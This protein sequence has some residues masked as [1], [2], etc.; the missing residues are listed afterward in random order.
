MRIEP[1]NFRINAQATTHESDWLLF[2]VEKR[3]FLE[4]EE[5]NF[6]IAYS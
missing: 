1:G 5:I 2:V 4:G 6:Y 3:N